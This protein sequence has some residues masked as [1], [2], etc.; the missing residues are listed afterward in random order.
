MEFILEKP[1]EGNN[2]Y[3]SPIKAKSLAGLPPAFIVTAEF[4]P[5]Y[6]EGEDYAKRLKEF[7]VPVKSKR[8][9]GAIHGFL[10]LPIKDL[11][12]RREALQ[13][14]QEELVDFL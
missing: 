7:N 12:E 2:P 9:L 1:E 6:L 3:A 4:D 14:I 13:D 10:S 5:L 11:P 8:Y